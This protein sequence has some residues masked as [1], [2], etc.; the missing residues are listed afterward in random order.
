MTDEFGH[1]SAVLSDKVADS[2]V[3]GF[4]RTISVTSFNSDDNDKHDQY[5]AAPGSLLVKY[6]GQLFDVHDFL[7][8]HPGGRLLLE[9]YANKVHMG[10]QEC[11][12]NKYNIYSISLLNM[13]CYD[14]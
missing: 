1:A 6:R 3:L 7:Q 5:E 8:E 13:L 14:K 2:E 9:N 4:K 10:L 12:I 11:T